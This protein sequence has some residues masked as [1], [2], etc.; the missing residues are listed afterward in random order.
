MPWYHNGDACWYIADNG[1]SINYVYDNLDRIV[2]LRYNN[3]EQT[4]FNYTY[5]R[6]DLVSAIT[7]TASGIAKIYDYD[8]V[9]RLISA[10]TENGTND[11]FRTHYTYDG[12][13]RLDTLKYV[14]S[15]A[16]GTQYT[17]EY[18]ATYG[19]DNRVNTFG[20]NGIFSITPTFDGLGRQSSRVLKNGSGAQVEKED[21]AFLAGNVSAQRPDATTTLIGSAT[22]YGAGTAG[23]QYSYEYD[24][25]G[26]LTA[27]KKNGTTLHT[28]T[29]DSLGQLTSWYNAAT[30][31]TTVYEYFKGGNIA[32]ITK[33]DEVRE[34]LY[35]INDQLTYYNEKFLT[36]DN[37][38]NPLN[39][40]DLI[41]LTWKNG[42]QMATFKLGDT[43]AS[44]DYDE[45]G[46]RTKKTVNGITTTFQ[47]D[48]SKIV[49]E[50]RNGFV[51][52][53]FYDENG[54]VLG[55]TYGGENYYFRKNFR[56]DVLAILNASGEVVVEYSYDPWGNILAVTGSLASTLG[57]DNPFRYRGYYYDTES[58]FYYL[59]SRYYDAKVC[60]FVNADDASTLT[61]TPTGLT[62]KNLY[63]YCDNNPVMRKDD[64]GE[65]WHILVG[66]VVGAIV[67]GV[68]KAVE[69][70]IENKPWN[71][72]LATSMLTG[73]ACGAL[74]AT[75]A[76]V[77][78]MAVGNAAISMAGNMADQI[79]ENKGIDNF[80]VGE[81][82]YE[83]VVG[84]VMGALGGPGTGTKNL[85]RQ[86][87]NSVAST[88]K[89]FAREGVKAG[90]KKIGK[91]AAY[92]CGQT[93][94]FYDALKRSIPADIMNSIANTSKEHLKRLLKD[95]YS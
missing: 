11:V 73:A 14:Y 6:F 93:R 81:M 69:N 38:G 53:Y 33:G 59:N 64:G 16:A 1:T 90:V 70:V 25:T 19:E 47:L 78:V 29:Y 40:R 35:G 46:I 86:G 92:Y 2:S 91:A 45:N 36:Y 54:S 42:R 62:D 95:I 13:S 5:N 50:N 32:S 26:N 77:A 68:V 37:V 55:I 8:T 87:I 44:Y 4:A 84:G 43:L 56:N 76:P 12:L 71:D 58:C 27:I 41:R 21:Y 24:K 51:Q 83:G 10:R 23:T 31:E 9:G 85:M 61:A 39:Y 30:N 34:F 74:A 79:I 82:V 15:T 89:T 28:Y 75:G 22:Y 60:R 67:S 20:L 94:Y 88:A 65:F 48:G 18:S 3:N 52:S 80:D 17:H 63:S 7:D 72:G 57:A 66:A 49:S